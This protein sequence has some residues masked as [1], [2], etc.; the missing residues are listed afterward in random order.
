MAHGKA[1]QSEWERLVQPE[2]HAVRIEINEDGTAAVAKTQLPSVP[3]NNIP[4]ELG[5]MFYQLRA[6]LDG[7]IYQA[8]AYVE[9]VEVP[10]NGDKVEFPICIDKA[11]FNSN[12][13]NRPP[14]PKE[15]RNWLLSVQPYIANDP[16]HPN[17]ALAKYLKILHDC[18]RID[19]HRRLH[20]V[21]RALF[22]I[23]AQFTTSPGVEVAD[24]EAVAGNIFE[25]E[26]EF[27]RF[28]VSGFRGNPT[29]EIK[30]QSKFGLEIA[31]EGVPVPEGGNLGRELTQVARSVAHI[32][33]YFKR[34]F[35]V[36][37][38]E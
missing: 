3:Q 15:L 27:L 29:A 26:A 1:V 35:T 10:S 22:E 5:E 19:R 24:V 18:A 20:L 7:L 21:G 11:K 12:A 23:G 33:D 25:Q 28:S 16:S 38:M 13:V 8:S 2:A 36:G 9:G 14:F 6:A 32:I 34:N 37:A 31:I 4:L 30:L 17:F